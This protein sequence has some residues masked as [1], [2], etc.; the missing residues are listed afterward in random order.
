MQKWLAN[1]FTNKYY[2]FTERNPVTGEEY[3][4]VSPAVTPTKS[5]QN[6]FAYINGNSNVFTNGNHTNGEA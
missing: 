2:L 5:P 3:T 1:F 4:I 6:G